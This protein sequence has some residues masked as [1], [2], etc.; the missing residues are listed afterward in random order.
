M[1]F[2][3]AAADLPAAHAW[4]TRLTDLVLDAGFDEDRCSQGVWCS[5]RLLVILVCLVVVALCFR[6]FAS[7]FGIVSLHQSAHH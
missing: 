2:E 7:E 5:S 4:L 3:V 1:F 6:R